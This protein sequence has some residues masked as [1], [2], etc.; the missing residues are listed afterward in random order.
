MTKPASRT[1]RPLLL[2]SSSLSLNGTTSSAR[3]CRMTVPAFTVFAVPHF[4]DAGHRRMSRAPPLSR[5]M[6]TA[7][8]RDEP[9]IT[10]GWCLSNSVWAILT[11]SFE[12]HDKF[13]PVG[14]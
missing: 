9:T 14:A 11:A 5:F 12:I 4:L 1:E 8:P 7:P 6:A 13:F 2:S 10:L 3:L